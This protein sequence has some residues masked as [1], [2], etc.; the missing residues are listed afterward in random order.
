W[1]R[2]HGTQ[3]PSIA[4]AWQGLRIADQLKELAEKWKQVAS[5]LYSKR[6]IQKCGAFRKE[7]DEVVDLVISA[8]DKNTTFDDAKESALEFLPHVWTTYFPFAEK[9]NTK[10]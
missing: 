8:I 7:V 1:L 6:D 2:S 9:N 3:F 5:G 10:K 4:A